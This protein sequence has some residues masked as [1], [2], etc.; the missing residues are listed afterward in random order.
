MGALE[1]QNAIKH[2][3]Q[4]PLSEQE[5]V[6]CSSTTHGCRGGDMTRAFKFLMNY[7]VFTEASYPYHAIQQ[8]C[9]NGKNSGVIVTGFVKIPHT[10]EDLKHAVGRVTTSVSTLL[11]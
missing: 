1:G 2:N 10:E 5:L 9:L 3:L 4:I 7:T 8:T 11:Y 6:D